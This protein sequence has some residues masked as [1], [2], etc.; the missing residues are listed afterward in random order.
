MSYKIR[1]H[2]VQSADLDQH[3]SLLHEFLTRLRILSTCLSHRITSRLV[4]M[5]KKGIPRPP[6]KSL[7]IV[8]IDGCSRRGFVSFPWSPWKCSPA[9]PRPLAPQVHSQSYRFQTVP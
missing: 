1:A 4:H 8:T 5:L 3:I 7:S 6:S 9:A 2:P